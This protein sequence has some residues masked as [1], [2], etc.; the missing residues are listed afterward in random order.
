VW[1]VHQRQLH[2]EQEVEYRRSILRAATIQWMGR[3]GIDGERRRE[4]YTVLGSS[5]MDGQARE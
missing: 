1:I 3:T 2:E 5:G 4:H